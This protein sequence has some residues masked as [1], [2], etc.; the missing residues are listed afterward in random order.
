MHNTSNFIVVFGFRLYV[1]ME[2]LCKIFLLRNVKKFDS[3]KI[4]KKDEGMEIDVFKC[5][6]ISTLKSARLSQRSMC[7]YFS[8]L[9][10][11]VAQRS[12]LCIPYDSLCP[13]SLS[14]GS[15]IPRIGE[16]CL[17]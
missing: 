5:S 14:D 15:A 8:T 13:G 11:H 2:I 4:S 16:H 12:M 1:R 3:Y 9:N 17:P 10:A 6:L 7:S